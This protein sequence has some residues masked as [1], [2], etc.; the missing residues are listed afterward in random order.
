MFSIWEDIDMDLPNIL[1]IIMQ[2]SL[3]HT[4]GERRERE[5]YGFYAFIA[6]PLV[7]TTAQEDQ[8]DACNLSLIKNM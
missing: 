7:H 4:I 3:V 5:S 6:L 2:S 1:H 8:D